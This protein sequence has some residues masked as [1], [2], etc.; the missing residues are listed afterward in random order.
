MKKIFLASAFLTIFVATKAQTT[1]NLKVV[2]SAITF[3]SLKQPIQRGTLIKTSTFHFY[4]ITEKVT[5]KTGYPAQP[6]VVVY[7]DGKKYKMKIQGMEKIL[8]VNKIQEVI[9]SNIEGDFK[10]W[11]GAT[12]FKLQNQQEWQQDAPTGTIF[13]NLYKPAV[14]IYLSSEGYKMKIEGVDE[15]PILVKK[16]R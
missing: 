6:E 12:K 1:D 9:E 5:Q 8:S 15:D 10:G 2:D 16:L 14:L 11:D 4:E 13:K 7:Q 3:K